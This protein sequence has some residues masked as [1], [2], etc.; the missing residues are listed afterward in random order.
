MRSA[1]LVLSAV[2]ILSST[3]PSQEAKIAARTSFGITVPVEIASNLTYMKGRINGSR[4]LN[5][6]L[7]TGSSLSIVAPSIARQI[8]LSSSG[9]TETDG[10][11][12]GSSETLKLV[13]NATLA[14]GGNPT[15]LRLKA[16]QIAI[17]PIEYVGIQTGHATDAF[18]GSNLFKN[19]RITVDYERQQAKFDA[20]E[21]PLPVGGESIPIEIKDGVPF[22]TATLQASDGSPVTSRFLLDSGTTGSLVLS[23][24]FLDAHPQLTAGRQYVDAPS[25]TAVGGT[26]NLKLIRLAGLEVGAFHLTAPVAAVPQQPTGPLLADPQ[27][28]GFIGAEIMRR[29]TVTWDYR[30][31]RMWLIP[32]GHLGDPF[33]ADASGMHLSTKL[34]DLKTVYVDAVLPGSP[35]DQAHLRPGDVL[36][37]I[38]GKPRLPLWQINDLLRRPGSTITLSVV[39]EGKEFPVTLHLVRLV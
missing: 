6:V 9:S 34:P 35:A 36:T 4:P 39:R 31:N 30:N 16:Q 37:T 2:V 20:F 8:A 18:F 23:K 5:V 33:E 27:M 38:N 28:A 19:F 25:V 32:N 11:G 12:R 21:A 13:Q 24:L 26:I 22:V 3:S 15:S 17:L 7:D 10:I 14:W 29:F 1:V